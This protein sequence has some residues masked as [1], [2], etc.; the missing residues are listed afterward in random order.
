MSEQEKKYDNSNS[1]AVWKNS[2]GSLS[3]AGNLFGQDFKMK[4][5]VNEYK[6]DNERAPDFK[7]KLKTDAKPAVKPV[8]TDL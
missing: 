5:F 1:V 7:G 4:L 3:L 6:K 2:D 8:E